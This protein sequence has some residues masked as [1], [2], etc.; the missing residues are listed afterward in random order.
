M[1]HPDSPSCTLEPCLGCPQR[2]HTARPGATSSIWV[3]CRRAPE[4]LRRP[5]RCGQPHGELGRRITA[6]LDLGRYRAGWRRLRNGLRRARYRAH[7]CRL[8]VGGAVSRCVQTTFRPIFSGRG[9]QASRCQRSDRVVVIRVWLAAEHGDLSGWRDAGG[10]DSSTTDERLHSERDGYLVREAVLALQEIDVLRRA[11]EE[12]CELLVK[13][14]IEERK[15]DVQVLPGS[16]LVDALPFKESEPEFERNEIDS[17]RMDTS[18]MV[19]VEVSAGSAI[20][21]GRR[22]LHVSGA[23]HSPVDRRALLY[24][25]QRAGQRDMATSTVSSTVRRT[26][27][28]RGRRRLNGEDAICL[29]RGGVMLSRAPR[30]PVRRRSIEAGRCSLGAWPWCAGPTFVGGVDCMSARR[31]PATSL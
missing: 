16:H 5:R 9:S 4:R 25:Y 21:F 24:T 31:R 26:S 22:L 11:C 20:F 12:L 27:T 7:R 1:P 18:A 30:R 28:E 15:I 13:S 17:A 23:N 10:G 8:Q 6:R 19:P 29:T 14:S 2:T 3:R